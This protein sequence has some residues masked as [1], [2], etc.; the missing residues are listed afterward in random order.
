[1]DGGSELSSFSSNE[2]RVVQYLSNSS[3][4]TFRDAQLVLSDFFTF[5]YSSSVPFLLEGGGGGGYFVL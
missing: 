3:L 4:T 5:T 2:V 1:V